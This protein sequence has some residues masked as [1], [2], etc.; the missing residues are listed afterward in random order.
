MSRTADVL[1]ISM[2]FAPL[3][4]PSLGLGLL[5]AAMDEIHVSSRVLY[6]S[7][8]FAEQIGERLYT[9]ICHETHPHD[10]LG[11]WIFS[12]SLSGYQSDH[13]RYV[14]DILRGE[15]KMSATATSY[16]PPA[17]EELIEGA[18]AA[19]AR[20]DRFLEEC[21]DTVIGYRPRIIGFTSVFLQQ[22]ASLSLAR[23]IKSALP[24][25]FVVFGGANCEGVMGKE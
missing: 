5:K 4:T 21:L 24:D 10:L 19:Q 12:D 9:K 14:A 2:P 1:L 13:N 23:L 8:C 16:L 3:V 15:L 11:E 20:A 7:L 18:L 22:V 17:S 25:S 6:F